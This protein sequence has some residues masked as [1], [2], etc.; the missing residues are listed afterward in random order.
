FIL[1]LINLVFATIGLA[2]SLKRKEEIAN[3]LF[4]F[5][6]KKITPATGKYKILDT[7]VIIDG[8]IVDL[9]EILLSFRSTAIIIVAIQ[10]PARAGIQGLN[11]IKS[12]I[13]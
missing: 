10:H 6:G 2:V 5:T 4:R 3:F 13:P 11:S 1:F 7:S 8:R 9:C 12:A